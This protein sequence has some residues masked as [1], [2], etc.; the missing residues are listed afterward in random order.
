MR[1]SATLAVSARAKELARSGLPVIELSAGE[2]DFPTPAPICEAAKQAIDEG[3]TRY[4]AN[5]GMPELREAI[6]AHL[7]EGGVMYSPAQIL[8]S[9]GAKQ[10]VAQALLVA[11]SQWDEVLI[12]APYWVSYPEMVRLAGGEPV[13]LETTADADYRL[14]A[15]QL[16]TAITPKTRVLLLC[17][18]SN[19]TG[20]VYPRE[21]L[22]A[23]AE[24]IRRHPDLIVISDEI[25]S[26]VIYDAEHI[27]FASLPGMVE[28][29]VTVDG[30]SKSFAMT[31]WRLGYLAGPEWLVKA[32]AKVQGQV[33]SAP[34]SISQ[35]AGIAALKMDKEPIV[36]MVKAFRERRD[37]VLA[38]LQ[39]IPGIVC[40]KPEGAFYLFPDC[41]AYFGRMT[42]SGRK[43]DDAQALCLY[44]LEEYHVALV[45]GDAF[46][47]PAGIR[48]SYAASPDDLHEALRRIRKG[49]AELLNR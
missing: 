38:D 41:S 47:S 42:A 7:A 15:E 20:S 37:F 18:P 2:P 36:E 6:A 12:P 11:V 23:I 4:T 44:L 48:I 34:C 49:L 1:P 45:P 19:P 9:N 29:T 40:P 33:T 27:R 28:Q 25:Y 8:C 3:F 46:G 31:G 32:A 13:I 22:E 16:E 5:P 10:S 14:S 24:I 39:A 35:K 26:Q 17:S 43:I 21:E 30:F